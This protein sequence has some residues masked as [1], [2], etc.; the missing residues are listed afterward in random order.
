MFS[1][2]HRMAVI[3]W[4]F[5]RYTPLL[6]T[7]AGV[8][9]G[10]ALFIHVEIMNHK[11]DARNPQIDGN[12]IKTSTPGHS[13]P[14]SAQPMRGLSARAQKLAAPRSFGISIGPRYWGEI[15]SA[16]RSTKG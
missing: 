15:P 7:K 9:G 1:A 14:A 10:G 5:Q 13:N 11:N 12:V 16:F 8:A 6:V 4:Q 2:P 3:G